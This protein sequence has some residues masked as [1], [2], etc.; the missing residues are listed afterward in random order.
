MVPSAKVKDFIQLIGK[1][2]PDD[3]DNLFYNHIT[4]LSHLKIFGSI[5]Y[6]NIPEPLRKKD[7]SPK[8]LK[9]I[10]IGYEEDHIKNYR[11]YI[12]RLNQIWITTHVTFSEQNNYD[13]YDMEPI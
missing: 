2:H 7:F 13:T 11:M 4:S 9:S 3:E 12:P 8:G 10:L 1:V 6:I 5:G